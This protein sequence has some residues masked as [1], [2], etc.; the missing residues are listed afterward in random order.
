[1]E[2]VIVL[3]GPIGVG[4]SS[5]ASAL[6]ELFSATTAATRDYILQQT[7]CEN[8]RRALQNAGDELDRKTGGAWI[9]DCIE[10]AADSARP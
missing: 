5:L 10:E 8:E 7:R 9:A 1:M 2:G 6:V 4:K 3:S